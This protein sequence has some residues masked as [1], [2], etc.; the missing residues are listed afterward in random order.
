MKFCYHK[1]QKLGKNPNFGVISEIQRAK[2]VV[3]VTYNFGGK[4]WGSH[5]NFIGKFL[6]QAPR[7]PDIEVPPGHPF[8]TFFLNLIRFCSQ[9]LPPP[10]CS[11]T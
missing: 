5:T 11:I 6:G 10:H 8:D 2:F 7:L 4:I 1:M 9:G 3:P